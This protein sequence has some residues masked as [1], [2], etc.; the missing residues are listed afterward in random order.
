[1]KHKWSLFCCLLIGALWIGLRIGYSEKGETLSVKVTTWDALGYYMFLPAKFI[2]ED[3]KKLS[4]IPAIDSVYQVSGGQFYQ[5]GPCKNGN[6][7]GKYLLGVS[8][9]QTPFFLGAHAYALSSKYPA[10]G[11]S[12]PYQMSI[13]WG[14]I[15]FCILALWLLRKILL[16]Y[17]SDPITALTLILFIAGSN[18]PQYVAIEGG[19]SHAWIFPLYVFILYTTIRWHEQKKPIWAFLSGLIIGIATISRPTEAVM[20]FVPLLWDAG[21]K[22]KWK[23]K[24]DFI[25]TNP[26]TLIFIFA[27]LF[28]G[29]LPQL[30]YWKSVTGSWIYDVG[31]KWDFLNPH[32]RVLIGWEKGWFIYTP[33][34]ILFVTGLF[35]MKKFSF[36]HAVITFCLLNIYIIISWHIWRYGGSY[37]TRALVQSYPIFAFPLAALLE[38]FVSSK[39][40]Y[41]LIFLIPFLIGVN[42]FQIY[43]YNRNI[44]H[45]DDMNRRYYQAIYLNPNPSPIDMSLLDNETIIRHEEDYQRMTLLKKKFMV[46]M[47]ITS[48]T[49]L[50]SHHMGPDKAKHVIKINCNIHVRRGLWGS[51]IRTFVQ[52]GP[53]TDTFRIRLFNALCH[54]G[55]DQDYSYFIPI[56]KSVDSSKI[57]LSIE[58]SPELQAF[59]NNIEL[60]DFKK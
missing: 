51:Y 19:Q 12:T 33:V 56:P 17:F 32:W 34:T 48:D 30:I 25:K 42:L 38:K 13:A 31:S 58:G 55:N 49:I 4:F 5:A 36:R 28:V 39:L 22:C 2:Y 43:Q 29:I 45:Y 24:W 10:D 1:M 7:A 35:F 6:L 60:I 23:E 53:H 27:G 52:Q 59:L 46:P 18:L 41:S 50:L 15:V 3:E 57:T 44:L 21:D 11:F 26:L 54:E 40:K 47:P 8:I 16:N 9:L 20:L 37:S 14:A